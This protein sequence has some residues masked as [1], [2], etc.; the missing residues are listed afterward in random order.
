MKFQETD[1]GFEYRHDNYLAFFGKKDSTLKNLR[2]A[3]PDL[4]WSWVKQVHG[5]FLHEA[6]QRGSSEVEADAQWTQSKNVGLITKTADCVPVLAHNKITHSILSIHAGWRG[7]AL[8]IVPK[9]LLQLQHLSHQIGDWEIYIGPHI[10]QDSFQI[11]ED[12]YLLLKQSASVKDEMWVKKT[13]DGYQADLIT[14]LKAQLHEIHVPESQIEILS[15]DTKTDTRFH[16]FRRDKDVS[17]RQIS[18]IALI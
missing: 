5:D 12:S 6:P 9:S 17:G 18:F 1:L 14:L 8:K 15:Y 13:A 11:K 3:Y 7:V 4:E 10:L 2:A 16:S